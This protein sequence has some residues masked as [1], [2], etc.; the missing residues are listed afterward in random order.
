LLTASKMNSGRNTGEVR[1]DFHHGMGFV[2]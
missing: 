2:F 1:R